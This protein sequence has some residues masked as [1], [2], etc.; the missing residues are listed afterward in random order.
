MIF[1]SNMIKIK[2]GVE[3]DN[4][5]V[6]RESRELTDLSLLMTSLLKRSTLG[7]M[8]FSVATE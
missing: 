4:P 8:L 6:D 3:A 7:P 5:D 2:L 1:S